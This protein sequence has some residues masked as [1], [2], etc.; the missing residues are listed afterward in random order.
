MVVSHKAD[1]FE[2]I[3]LSLLEANSKLNYSKLYE[4]VNKRLKILRNKDKEVKLSTRDFNSELN[5]LVDEGLLNRT[6]DEESKN[7]IK[8]V[9]F[10]LTDEAIKQH[11]FDILGISLEKEYRRNLFHLI[12]FYQAFSPTSHISKKRIEEILSRIPGPEKNLVIESNTHMDDTNFT[13]TIYKPVEYIQIQ[14]T[15]LSDVGS[16]KQETIVSYSYRPLS[17]SEEEI[18]GYL[19][20]SN[21]EILMPFVNS[22]GF[23]EEGIE[24]QFRKAFNILRDAQLI[25]PI[26]DV[27]GQIRFFISDQSLRDLINKIWIIHEHQLDML[28]RK[29]H[30]VKAP[31]EIEKHWLER[32][33]GKREAGRIIREAELKRQS[34]SKE[35]AR[36]IRES[37]EDDNKSIEEFMLHISKTFE[38][39][40]LEYDFPVDLIERVCLGEVFPRAPKRNA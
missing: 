33:L 14:K 38:Q 36:Q 39:V 35:K 15:E 18:M 9:Y 5:I 8:P 4:K 10:S 11:Q 17:F 31:N 24:Q 22:I 30:Y 16:S 32:I 3:K 28:R 25:S 12:L 6:T 26:R 40:I 34:I 23:R 19:E 1:V 29:M 37:L 20:K 27:F 2:A 7:K 13:Q 21:N